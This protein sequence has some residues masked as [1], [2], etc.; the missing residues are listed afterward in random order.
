MH[1]GGP[2][3]AKQECTLAFWRK[4]EQELKA[5]REQRAQEAGAKEKRKP[6]PAPPKAAGKSEFC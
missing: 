2:D 4:V 6:A 5:G 3:G 1:N